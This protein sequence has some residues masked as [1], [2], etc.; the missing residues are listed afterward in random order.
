MCSVR[1]SVAHMQANGATRK[2]RIETPQRREPVRGQSGE[3][4]DGNYVGEAEDDNVAVA[5]HQQR[6]AG[7]EYVEAHDQNPIAKADAVT[8]VIGTEPDG[9][10]TMNHGYEKNHGHCSAQH[11]EGRDRKPPTSRGLK[12]HHGDGY[13]HGY[14]NQSDQEI[15]P[16]GGSSNLARNIT[17]QLPPDQRFNQEVCA[18]NERQRSEEKVLLTA[19]QMSARVNAYRSDDQTTR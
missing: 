16:C 5:G 11:H 13:E 3:H 1:L 18:K 10:G 15:E 12:H 6:S 2:G 8:K 19:A 14:D 17:A 4:D 7:G 9:D